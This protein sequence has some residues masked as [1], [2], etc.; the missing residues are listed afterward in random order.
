MSVK[1]VHIALILGCWHSS[2]QLF[3]SQNNYVLFPK[4]EGTGKIL[5]KSKS[6]FW[7]SARDIPGKCGAFQDISDKFDKRERPRK[8]RCVY[9]R[10]KREHQDKNR[11]VIAV[12]GLFSKSIFCICGCMIERAVINFPKETDR[13][14]HLFSSVR[15]TEP[16]ITS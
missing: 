12:I 1:D 5:T 9:L 6:A 3:Y 2:H 7:V 13:K 10:K 11:R 4:N 15:G 16:G 14:M 8:S